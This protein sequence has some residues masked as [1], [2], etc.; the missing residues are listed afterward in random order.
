MTVTPVRPLRGGVLVPSLAAAAALAVLIALGVWQVERK[1]WKEALIAT[2]AERLAAP[3]IAVPAPAAWPRLGADADEFLHVSATVEFDNGTEALVYTS[4]STLRDDPGGPGYWVFAPARLA[5]GIVIVNRGF[6][7][8]DR[9]DAA[10]RPD[11][12]IAGPVAVTGV[13]RWPEPPGLFT[14]AADPARNLWFSRDSAAIAAAKGVAAAPFYIEL[15]GPEP[16]GGLP[17]PARLKPNLPNNHL[18]YAI[19]WFGL[20]AVLIGVYAAWLFSGWRQQGPVSRT[21]GVPPALPAERNAARGA[22]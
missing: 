9:Q 13:L 12:E 19:T 14:P 21:A 6:V 15:E 17:H 5:D 10:S 20:A 11:G 3:P 1:A 18:Q 8:Q 2:I 7:P 4:G 16:P 22:Q